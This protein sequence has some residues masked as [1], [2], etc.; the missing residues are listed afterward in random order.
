MAENL[1]QLPC[2]VLSHDPLEAGYG[3]LRLD[4][5]DLARA[6]R[7]GQFVHLQVP[8]LD[9]HLLR[10]PFSICDATADGVLT[11]VYKVVGVGTARLAECPVG[12]EIDVLGPLGHGFT[13]P[14]DGRPYILVAGGYGCA[15]M[16]FAARAAAK[17]PLVLLGARTAHDLL[18]T[19]EF[20]ALGCRVET[21]TDDGSRGRKGLVTAL[22]REALAAETE[23]LVAACGPKPMLKAVA[24]LCQEFPRVSCEVSLDEIMCCGVG[25][26]FGCVVKAKDAAAPSGWRYVRSCKEGPVFDGRE[27]WWDE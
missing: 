6:A 5:G 14:A 27:I 23:T 25:A 1:H 16:H 7:P 11:I 24:L 4:A 13:P 15:A 21:A 26:C 10:R 19:E 9:G 18:L 22:L 20:A 12:A 17:P 3:R 2:R 8:G